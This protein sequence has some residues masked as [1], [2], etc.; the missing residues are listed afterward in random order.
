MLH[1]LVA[2]KISH[3]ISNKDRQTVNEYGS[4]L[5]TKPAFALLPLLTGHYHMECVVNGVAGDKNFLLIGI[6]LI[7]NTI[8]FQ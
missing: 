4:T 8:Y 7:I 3:P 5:L 1:P 2:F 6:N